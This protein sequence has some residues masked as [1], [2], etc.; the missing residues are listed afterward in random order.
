MTTWEDI[1]ERGVYLVRDGATLRVRGPKDDA[2]VAELAAAV[3][4]RKPEMQA[5][6]R[7]ASARSG[8]CD[9]CGDPLPI[10]RGGWC[11]LCEIAR[12]KALTERRPIGG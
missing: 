6:S 11:G 12:Y 5:P 1:T 4:A 7:R 10:G 3:A 9:G 2:L 8:E